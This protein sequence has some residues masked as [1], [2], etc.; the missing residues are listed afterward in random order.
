MLPLNAC[1]DRLN[2][3]PPKSHH[4]ENSNLW[5]SEKFAGNLQEDLGIRIISLIIFC[6]VVLLPHI[7]INI[8]EYIV[9]LHSSMLRYRL[10]KTIH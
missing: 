1:F 3:L 4:R 2:F 8:N 6:A 7:F 10:Y 5:Q 9:N